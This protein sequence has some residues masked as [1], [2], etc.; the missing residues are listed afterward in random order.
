MREE[1]GVAEAVRAAILHRE[2]VVFCLLFGMAVGLKVR[3]QGDA[4][5]KGL[6]KA[7]HIAGLPIIKAV[8]RANIEDDLL[9]GNLSVCPIRNPDGL[10][11][12]E[13]WFSIIHKTLNVHNTLQNRPIYL[14]I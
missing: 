13:I 7:L 10:D 1:P 12:S 9:L 8:Q 5:L 3:E 4:C 2:M 6:F 14:L 11:Q